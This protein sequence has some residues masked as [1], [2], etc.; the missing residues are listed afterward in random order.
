[1]S[2]VRD[3]SPA[4][5][6]ALV[7]L[8]AE[9]GYPTVEEAVATLL[10]SVTAEGARVLVAEADGVVRGFAVVHRMLT[11]HRAAPVAYLS[12]L[13]VGSE[14]RGLGLGRQ[15]VDAVSAIGAGWGCA[16]LELTSNDRRVHAHQ[17]YTSLGFTSE[18]RK[19]RRVIPASGKSSLT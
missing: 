12:A 16:T 4:D 2:L 17:F 19:F 15:L 18:S 3:A 13:V 14:A 6:P 5:V 1:V 8:L 9:L 11:L 10:S 7:P